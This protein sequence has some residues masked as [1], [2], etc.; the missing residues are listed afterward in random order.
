MHTVKVLVYADALI[1]QHIDIAILSKMCECG[2][3]EMHMAIPLAAL[4]PYLGCLG[5]L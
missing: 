4:I 3:V 5:R 2:C 1:M